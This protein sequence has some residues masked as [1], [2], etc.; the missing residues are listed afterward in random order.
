MPD[1]ALTSCKAGLCEGQGVVGEVCLARGGSYN[2]VLIS[3]SC[4]EKLFL[5]ATYNIVA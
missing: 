1:G 4:H 5:I 2:Y 3:C